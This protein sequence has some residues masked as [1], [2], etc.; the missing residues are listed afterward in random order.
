L[1]KIFRDLKILETQKVKFENF[2][3]STNLFNSQT[4]GS[5][6]TFAYKY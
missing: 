3:W 5:S 4:Y 1:K 2:P 6:P